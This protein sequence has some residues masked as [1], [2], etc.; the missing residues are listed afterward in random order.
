MKIFRIT[1]EE[2][3]TDNKWDKYENVKM[4]VQKTCSPY[5]LSMFDTKYNKLYKDEMRYRVFE[6]LKQRIL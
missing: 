5:E 2:I 1:Y 6:E 3:D 4:T